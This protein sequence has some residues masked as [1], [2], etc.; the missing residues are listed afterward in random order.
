MLRHRAKL[1]AVGIAM[2][3]IFV[4]VAF[5]FSNRKE[6][7]TPPIDAGVLQPVDMST[8]KTVMLTPYEDELVPNMEAF[9][10]NEYIR[11]YI[12]RNTAAMA[13]LDKRSG[14]VWRSNPE[15]LEEDPTAAPFIKGRLASQLALTYTT[16]NG[17]T[18]EYFS[19]NDSVSYGSQVTVTTDEGSV[20]VTYHFGN[21]EKGIESTP[22]RISEERF[23]TLL[24]SR[25]EDEADR[26]ALKKRYKYIA[27]ENSYERREIPKSGQKAFIAL[28]EKAGYTEEELAI[29][30]GAAGSGAEAPISGSPSFQVTISYAL[31][32]ENLLASVNMNDL[33]ANQKDYRVQAIGV[34]GNFGAADW[35]EKGYF[36]VP[37]GSGALVAFNNDNRLAQ[38][39]SIPIYGEDGAIT[40]NEKL[41]NYE[42][43][44]MPVY[45]IKKQNGALFAIIEQGDALAKVL[46][47]TSG[48]Q[49]SFN[50]IGNQFQIAPRDT[51][52]L[53]NNEQMIRMPTYGYSGLLQIRYA[54]LGAE[55]SSYSGMANYYREYL[56]AK[57]ALSPLENSGNTPFYLE[58]LGS[59]RKMKS[60]L[61]LTY[62]DQTALTDYAQT[63]RILDQLN[64]GGV[65][66]IH[67]NYLG[68]QQGG[69]A[70]SFPARTTLAREVSSSSQWAGLQE[71][72]RQEGGGFYPDVALLHVYRDNNGFKVSRDAVQMLSR[73]YAK[74]YAFNPATFQKDNE[75]FSNYLLSPGRL[76]DVVN[77]FL[78]DY[79]K[80]NQGTLSLRDLGADLNSD[81]RQGQEW[82]R[83]Q[84]KQRIVEQFERF[85]ASIGDIIV[86]GGNIYAL[87]YAKH[88][89]DAPQASNQYQLAERAVPFYQM[90]LHG[91]VQY[92]GKPFNAAD[93]QSIH[94]SI[95]Y[96]METGSN[97]I[98]SL[99]DTEPAQLQGTAFMNWYSGH[100][101]DWLSQAIDAYAEVNQALKDVAEAYIVAHD[102]IA[103]Q[104]YRTTY[105]NGKSVIV[106]YS[107]TPVQVDGVAVAASSY[108]WEGA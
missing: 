2:L 62:E 74:V 27:A 51:V 67:L 99:Y 11:F 10:E 95:L 19:F 37:D 65:R 56:A 36:L 24:L 79:S 33:I 61:G 93:D 102:Q 50:L 4:A 58:L 22:V 45:G 12:N 23:E 42:V 92:A 30:N 25:L 88:I 32:G 72:L 90:V 96:A 82:N 80:Y 20:K 98:F 91:Y 77:R 31:D 54:F 97:V 44:R 76:D 7:A 48:T 100:A 18:N 84:T 104:V 5:L 6:Y 14:V 9:M 34:L 1:L 39:L 49:H 64:E 94:N 52:S 35:E 83:E 29:D 69:Y 101:A 28:F 85:K 103:Y 89:L 15:R 108:L 43:S 17:Q 16:P 13:V 107:R 55:Q 38:T 60:F 81:F 3:C 57:Y 78:N 26:D 66:R 21:P 59:I 8:I 41:A 71:R 87:P 106:N 63:M 105:S 73:Q 68:W 40:K 86:R 53:S 70:H 47:E 75:Q 46:V